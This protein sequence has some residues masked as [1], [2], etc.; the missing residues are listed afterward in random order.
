MAGPVDYP[1]ISEIKGFVADSY[2]PYVQCLRSYW[3]AGWVLLATYT[4]GS[5]HNGESQHQVYCLG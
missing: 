4:H 2:E 1:E 5:L 3:R